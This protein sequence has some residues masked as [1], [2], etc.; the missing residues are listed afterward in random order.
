MV[1]LE[2]I[3]QREDLTY[4]NDLYRDKNR[5]GKQTTS[6]EVAAVGA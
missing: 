3:L 5:K 1:C 4:E 2:M 6:F